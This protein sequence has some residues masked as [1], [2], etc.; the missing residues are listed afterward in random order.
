MDNR[1]IIA[2]SPHIHG[3]ESTRN[4]MRDV[5]IA[6]IPAFGISLFVFGLPALIV[7]GI[8]V[9]SCVAFE[10]VI[11]RFLMGRKSSVGDLSAVLTGV[12]LAFNLPSDLPIWMIVMGAAVAIG[13]GKMSFGGLGR[14]PFNPALVGRVFLLLS[15]PVAM[16]SFP[17]TSMTVDAFSGATPLTLVREALKNGETLSNIL[18][19]IPY[20]NLI[21][22]FTGGSLGEISALALLLGFAY[23]LIRKVIKWITPV[24]ILGTMAVFAGILHLIDP[25]IYAGPTFH[26]LTGGAILGAVFM[27]TDYVTCPMTDKGKVIYA[28][29][30]GV[31]T[32]LIRVWG[33][34]P[35]GISFAILIMNSVVPLLNKYIRPR[36]FGV[37]NAKRA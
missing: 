16:T 17:D 28:I 1:L 9:A 26:I 33:A 30:I 24:T 14:N 29:G 3:R 20:G 25:E 19:G 7:T 23:M 22:G 31:I 15:F 18:P 34:Y 4:I 13:I 5:L 32:M 6:L 36:L 21:L 35:E 12:L 10:Y 37:V 11:Q 27:A 2:P 8:S